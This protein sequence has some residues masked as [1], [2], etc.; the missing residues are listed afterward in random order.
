FDLDISRLRVI[1][2]QP[3][4]RTMRHG[5]RYTRKHGHAVVGLLT[6][7]LC[8]IAKAVVGQ[9]RKRMRFALDLLQQQDIGL[10]LVQPAGHMRLPLPDRVDVPGGD[11][12]STEKLVPQPQADLALGFRTAKWL[13][14]SSS[15]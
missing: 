8:L 9:G 7:R 3:G 5:E 2:G 4:K 12:H 1:R 6:N 10:T 11:L 13:P 14:I 15:V